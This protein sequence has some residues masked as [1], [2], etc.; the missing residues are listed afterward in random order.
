VEH[1][2]QEAG[3][4]RYRLP[5]DTYAIVTR[6]ELILA[7]R[8]AGRDAVEASLLPA[9]FT[10][11]RAHVAQHGWFYP[12]C[13]DTLGDTLATVRRFGVVSDALSGKAHAGTAYLQG[14]FRSFW[15]VDDG[16]ARAFAKDNLL[17]NVL[18]YR[19]GLNNSKDYTYTLSSGEVVSTRETFDINIKNVRRGFVVQRQTAS[20]F[21]PSVACSIYR[22]WVSGTDAPVVWDASCGFGA[23]LLGFAAA[24]PKGTYFGNEP[25][26]RTHADVAALAD[27]LVTEGHLARATIV[28]AGSEVETAFEEK[29]LDLVF[30]S[31]P[32]FDLERYYDEPGQCWRDYPTLALWREN[33]LLPTLAAAHA[34]LKDDALLVLNVDEARRAVVVEA[35]QE[36]GF[37]LVTE[38]TLLLG[39]DH[40]ARKR[41]APK[42]ARGEPVLVFAKV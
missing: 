39:S 34:G 10:F 17:R 31:P 33:Y 32:Y 35:A 26:S 40:F 30:T 37:W 42:D 27:D 18:R 25:A 28:R 20:F 2:A 14:R 21:K 12:T 11:F 23:R 15:N 9:V 1:L 6:D 24:F 4:G 41:D 7:T 38:Q 36:A 13:S 3:E 29:T 5:D 22:R 19:L 16:P 8:E